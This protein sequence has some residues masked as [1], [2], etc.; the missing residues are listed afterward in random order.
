MRCG[1]CGGEDKF[2]LPLSL[3]YLLFFCF[4][5]NVVSFELTLVVVRVLH[6]HPWATPF[7]D[8]HAP[9]SRTGTTAP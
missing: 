6:V 5:A 2:T 8:F 1:L 4:F 9:R 3:I 7:V